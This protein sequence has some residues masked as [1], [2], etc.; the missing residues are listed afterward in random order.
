MKKFWMMRI[1]KGIIFFLLFGV[2]FGYVVMYLWNWLMP[3]LFGATHLITFWEAVGII[4]LS[5]I[6]FG[7]LGGHG[8]YRACHCHG[9][10]HGGYWGYKWKEK[11]S[12]MTPEEREKVK[13]EWAKRCCK[14]GYG[15]SNEENPSSE[16]E[17]KK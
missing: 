16:S 17:N 6:L 10:K 3:M 11:L 12:H 8:R 7:G 1:V 4:I 13:A 15:E 2:L 14:W 9:H 5:K